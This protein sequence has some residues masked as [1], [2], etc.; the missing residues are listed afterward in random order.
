[1]NE[2]DSTSP[3]KEPSPEPEIDEGVSNNRD[4]ESTPEPEMNQD[5]ETF[6]SAF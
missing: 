6:T 5:N 1:M 3:D 2:G 4:E